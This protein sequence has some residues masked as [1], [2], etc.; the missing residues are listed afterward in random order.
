M[1]Y[2]NMEK[3]YIISIQDLLKGR[4]RNADF[5][6][7]DDKRI[8]LVRHSALNMICFWSGKVSSQMRK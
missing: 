2:R 1:K 3:D 4:N 5:D 7:A 8:K 6:T